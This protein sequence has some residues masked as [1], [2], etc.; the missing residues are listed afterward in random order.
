MPLRPGL[1][2]VLAVMQP[3]LH[4]STYVFVS[5]ADDTP[6]ANLNVL[7]SMR[8]AEGLSL[9]MEEA[10]A[11]ACGFE[12][13]FRAAWIQLEIQTDLVAVGITAALAE[14]LTEYNISCNVVA[15]AYHDHLFV[16]Y[17]LAQSAMQALAQVQ[18]TARLQ[19]QRSAQSL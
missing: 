7:A 1:A 6:M 5:V 19:L 13:M 14:A 17:A 3:R 15:G 10:Q 12:P 16:P 8:E 11:L 18:E 9:I 4:S 2:E